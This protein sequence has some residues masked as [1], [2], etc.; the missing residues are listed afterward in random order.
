MQPRADPL[1]VRVPLGQLHAL[2]WRHFLRPRHVLDLDL[3][4]ELVDG[5]VR[6]AVGL[7]QRVEPLAD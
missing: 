5:A 2:L 3:V 4:L 1:D 6:L 7:L